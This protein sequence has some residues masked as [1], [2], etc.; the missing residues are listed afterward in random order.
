MRRGA[1]TSWLGTYTD[2]TCK[3]EKIASQW[4]LMKRQT[5]CKWIAISHTCIS[6]WTVVVVWNANQGVEKLQT[7]SSGG[8]SSNGGWK[9]RELWIAMSIIIIY[10]RIYVC[11]CFP[12][13]FVF[14]FAVPV[15]AHVN[16]R[17]KMNKSMPHH[18]RKCRTFKQ[19]CVIKFQFSLNA[20]SS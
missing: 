19:G 10:N 12:S 14:F 1:P 20:N 8:S 15:H 4:R 6:G 18:Q 17:G 7:N 9:K 16:R 3:R 11:I 5:E 13:I 2:S